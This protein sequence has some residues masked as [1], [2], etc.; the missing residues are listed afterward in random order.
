VLLEIFGMALG[1]PD[2][3]WHDVV[4]AE[5]TLVV[6]LGDLTA[7]WTN[8]RRRSTPHR[9]VPGPSQRRSVAFFFDGD[10]DARFECPP[11]LP[12]LYAKITG[13]RTLEPADARNT[14]ADRG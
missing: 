7:Q 4:P 5:G 14:A 11:D 10:H 6:N 13:G 1:L 12:H 8:D 9:V 2:G 3:V